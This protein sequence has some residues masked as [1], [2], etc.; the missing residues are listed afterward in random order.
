MDMDLSPKFPRTFLEAE[1]GVYYTWSS[2]DSLVLREAKVG[3]GKLVLKPQGF[4]LPHYADCPKIG[5]VLEGGCG[6]GLTYKKDK[7]IFIDLKKGDM[8]PLPLGSVSWWYNHGSSDL[9][10]V[11]IGEASKAYLPGE[12]SYFVF[13]GTISHL[14]AFS[15]EFI[16]RTYHMN[17]EKA[18]ILANSQKGVLFIKLGEEEAKSFPQ[19]NQDS[20]NYI[21]SKNLET[22]LPN[23]DV[24]KGGKSTILTE[25]SFPLLEEVGLSANRLA[26]E[27]NAI[28]AP[29]YASDA[30]IYYV[31]KGS[32]NVQIAGLNGKLV[33]DTKVESGQLFVVPRFFMVSILADEEG[34][35]CFCVITS[36]CP[37]I[38]EMASKDSMFNAI[39]SALQISL[40][41]TPEFTQVFKGIIETGT[42]IVP[43]INCPHF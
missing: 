40:N 12:I 37:F 20:F 5:F 33:L 7:M 9:V 1:A 38:G 4:V 25:A 8:I 2:S 21:W 28:R 18:Q 13:S 17:T 23:V 34:L 32:G 39:P 19:P 36:A 6:V 22:E 14:S 11:F 41:V 15:P 31:S 42:T 35:E 3:A 43:P 29:M 26:L 27:A 16:A 30:Q 10:I 24:K